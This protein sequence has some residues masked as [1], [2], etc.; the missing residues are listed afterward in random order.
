M[1]MECHNVF[2]EPNEEDDTRS[3]Y[4]PEL[5]GNHD[6]EAPKIRFDKFKQPLKIKKFNIWT[7]ENSKFTCIGE[8][9]NDST[10]GKVTDLLHEFQDLFPTKFSEMK[11]ISR[12]LGEMNIPL[13]PDAKLVKQRPYRLNTR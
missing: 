6:I 8:Y 2:G 9:W 4:I 13:K 7:M 1:M 12:D 10:M 11:G 3:I 5:K